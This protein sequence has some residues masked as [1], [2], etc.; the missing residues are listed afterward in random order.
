MRERGL[1]FNRFAVSFILYP[2]ERTLS[3]RKTPPLAGGVS[4]HLDDV[5]L[6]ANRLLNSLR[7][8]WFGRLTCRCVQLCP[9]RPSPALKTI[10]YQARGRPKRNRIFWTQPGR[11]ERIEPCYIERSNP[12]VDTSACGARTAPKDTREVF[13]TP[14]PGSPTAGGVLL[15]AGW[16]AACD[17]AIEGA[18]PSPRDGLMVRPGSTC[19]TAATTPCSRPSRGR[20]GGPFA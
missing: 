16:L 14:V 3:Q 5:T 11:P 7:V 2:H 17:A 15:F 8:S 1:L 19:F 13:R 4:D 18:D 20:A 6:V 10:C 9:L 12:R